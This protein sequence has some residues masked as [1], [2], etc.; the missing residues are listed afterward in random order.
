[1]PMFLKLFSKNYRGRNTSKLILRGHHHPDMK[2]RQR[3]CTKRKLQVNITDE[4][5]CKNPQHNFSRQNPATHQKA[6][7]PSSSWAYSRDARI[8][9]YM[10]I[11]QCDRPY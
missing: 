6:H 5:R 3:Q 11:N 10:Q 1:M 4:H 7:T 8:L 2:T 9:Q